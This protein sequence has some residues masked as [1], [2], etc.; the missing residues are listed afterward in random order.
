MGNQ[1][2]ARL[3]TTVSQSR[4]GPCLCQE[5][6]P[7]VQPVPRATLL[8]PVASRSAFAPDTSEHISTKPLRSSVFPAAA[9]FDFRTCIVETWSFND[10]AS[11]SSLKI[12][13]L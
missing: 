1:L 3:V 6:N 4:C 13:P 10:A 8:L 5:S 7:V 9:V 2:I 12:E 11:H